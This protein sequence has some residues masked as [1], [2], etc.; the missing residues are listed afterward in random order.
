MISKE[1]CDRISIRVNCPSC[2]SLVH[3]DNRFCEQCGADLAV[4]T[5]LAEQQALL[6]L[7][8]PEGTLLVPE[9]FVPRIGDYL[10]DRGLLNSD[11]LRSALEYQDKKSRDNKPILLGQAL[12]ELGLISREAIDEAVTAQILELQNT[13]RK[14]NVLLKQRIDER[15]VELRQAL[16]RLAELNQLKS[17]FIANISHELRTPLTH[18]KGYLDI[19]S[20]DTLGP[21]SS[22][23]KDAVDVM[24]RAEARLEQLIE[25]LIQFSVVSR[26]GMSLTRRM[27]DPISLVKT[28]LE[29][30][31][32][33]A[34]QM[35]ITLNAE[36]PQELPHLL[37]DEDKL[38]WALQQ[39]IENAVKFTPEGGEVIVKC[40]HKE[41]GAIQFAVI[42]NGIGISEARLFEIFEPFHQLDSS[43][44]RRYAGTGLGLA[45]V[46]QIVEA[47]GGQ[48]S[49]SS[50]VGQGSKFEFVLPI[51]LSEAT[52][53]SNTGEL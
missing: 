36:Y 23:Q 47:H 34:V 22:K 15:T 5:L 27:I 13:L 38:G 46:R 28:S 48:I 7:E 31:Q 12:L 9:L 11:Q 30:L 41:K 33:K 43:S 6:S 17:N 8:I 24:K 29:R 37:L 35:K 26:S 19:L 44:T 39:L 53:T 3:P 45:M 18:L 20:F 1:S 25:D 40:T 16:D 42:D 32:N 21:L 14:I 10:L 4:T 52:A 2:G 49:V 51:H 50:K